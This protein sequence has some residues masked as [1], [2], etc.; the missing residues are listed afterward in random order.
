[1]IRRLLLLQ[2]LVT[3]VAGN[4]SGQVKIRLFAAKQLKVAL[5]SVKEG[6]FNIDTYDNKPLY[7]SEGESAVFVFY[8]GKVAV[9]ARN[10]TSFA[11]DSLIM[12]GMTGT[13]VFSVRINGKSDAEQKYTGDLQCYPDLGFLVLID[14]C[15]ID[16]YIAGVVKAEGG[17]GRNIEYIKTQ[18]LIARTYMYRYFDRHLLDRYNLCDDTHCQAYM[19]I[20]TNQLIIKAVNETSGL[21]VLGSDSTLI[22][23]AFHSNCGGE[24]VSSEN[25]WLSGQPYLKKVSDPYCTGSNNARWSK[26]IPLA[27]WKAYLNKSG[28]S[29]NGNTA[30]D[31]SYSQIIRQKDYRI[32]SFTIPFKKI[33]DD[34]NLKSTF[35]SVFIDGNYIILK[36][37]GYGHGVGLCQEGAMAMAAKGFNYKQILK[38][39]YTD[40]I[41]S[42]IKSARKIVTSY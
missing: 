17:T 22:M 40:I 34:L 36:G 41:I 30:Q 12:K 42:D 29:S 10:T 8:G 23:S 2:L 1:M 20:T 39:Y 4:I 15:N 26:K 18:A 3:I 11:C 38:F 7:L 35:F 19:G 28:S 27:D 21:V 5:I 6:K 9:K 25:V 14:S 16:Q 37:R 31:F 33:R 32:G 24:T 13:D